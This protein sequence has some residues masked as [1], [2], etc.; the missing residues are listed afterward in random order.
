MVKEL[1]AE[2]TQLILS[3]SV[4]SENRKEP[5]TKEMEKAAIFCLAELERQK[6]GGIILKQPPEKIA[7]LAE[8]CYPFWLVPWNELT[9]LFDGLNTTSHTVTY[10]PIPDVKAF[11]Q[12]VGNRL[13]TL[14]THMAFLNDNLNYFQTLG[15][16]RDTPINGLVTDSSFISEFTSYL[17]NAEQ[18]KA[19]PSDSIMLPTAL[20]EATLSSAKQEL[21]D[22]RTAFKEDLN[23]LYASMKL[24]NKTT[25]SFL[26]ILREKIKAIQEEYGMEIKKQE[27]TT[28]PK[29]DR[30]RE[31]YD[32]RI[33]SLSQNFEK[34]L[35]PFQKEKVKLEK[36]EEQTL[37]KIERYKIEAKTSSA[38][39][40]TVGERKWKE[41]IS[42]A[43]NQLSELKAQTKEVET[44]TKGTEEKRSLEIFNLRSE[45]EAK[46]NDARKDLLELEASRDAK[47]QVHKQ[48]M[49]KLKQLTSTIIEQISTTAKMRETG[50]AQLEKLAIHQ[51]RRDCSLAY[52]PFYVFCFQS[53]KKKRYAIVP[54][55]IVNSVGFSIKLKG[56]LGKARVK[57]I[58]EP[59][60]KTTASFLGRLPLLIEQNAVLE[61]EIF[62]AG[63]KVDMLKPEST[64]ELAAKGLEQLKMEGWFSEKDYEAFRQMLV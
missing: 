1:S 63:E 5:F 58:L 29:V 59:R 30:I 22:L 37:S 40:D 57:Q 6:G 27:A 15:G 25:N 26:K 13:K 18:T 21:E 39:K 54:P 17:V 42:E 31:E 12:N 43:K 9:L 41:K 55:S 28:M 24:L 50:V 56:A 20:D 7:F 61:R 16:Q 36:T 35:L 38:N 3:F 14:E 19:L 60:F 8:A 44:K 62:E 51:K 34:Q 53:E 23:R 46:I 2:V 4:L 11:I 33:T 52:V 49:D 64:I 47:I 10:K 32:E 48:E 45:S